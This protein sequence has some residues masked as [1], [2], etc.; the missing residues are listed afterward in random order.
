MFA[1]SRVQEL[2]RLGTHLPTSSA[3]NKTQR[4]TFACFAPYPGRGGRRPRRL[5]RDRCS[6]GAHAGRCRRPARSSARRPSRIAR[7]QGARSVAVRIKAGTGFDRDHRRAY[8]MPEAASPPAE[9]LVKVSRKAV[10]VSETWTLGRLS[11]PAA[12]RQRRG[13]APRLT[14]ESRGETADLSRTNSDQWGL[15]ATAA[16]RYIASASS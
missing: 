7:P 5:R 6:C 2:A 8:L 16:A 3:K 4:P 12:R 14:R 11:T 1:W 15:P 13:G 9:R 10:V